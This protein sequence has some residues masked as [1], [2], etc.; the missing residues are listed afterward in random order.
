MKE[1]LVTILFSLF[2]FWTSFGLLFQLFLSDNR[3]YFILYIMGII[4]LGGLCVSGFLLLLYPTWLALFIISIVIGINFFIERLSLFNSRVSLLESSA[5]HADSFFIREAMAHLIPFNLAVI[6]LINIVSSHLLWKQITR[7]VGGWLSQGI[8]YVVGASTASMS[9]HRLLTPSLLNIKRYSWF[10]GESFI[11]GEGSYHFYFNWLLVVGLVHLFIWSVLVLSDNWKQI[12]S[13]EHTYQTLSVY[14][15]IVFCTMIVGFYTLN[16]LTVLLF[17]LFNGLTYF[18]FI[19]SKRGHEINL[20][21][22]VP[23]FFKRKL[24]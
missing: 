2:I 14:S 19:Q 11:Y 9:I 23:H 6:W 16:W 20:N 15:L 21:Q 8:I 13:D 7:Y 5:V 24:F 17:L 10:Q 18:L 22:L 4:L 3:A 1:K 12:I